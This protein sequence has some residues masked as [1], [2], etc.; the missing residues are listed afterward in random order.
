MAAVSIALSSDA[1]Y[2]CALSVVQ[3][4]HG[5]GHKAYFA[6]GCV[7]DMLL[8]LTPKDFDVATSATPDQ[9]LSLFAR[10]KAVGAHFGVILVSNE[11]GSLDGSNGAEESGSVDIEVAT[12]RNDGIYIDGRRPE[13]V[14]F[15]SDPREDVIR[16]DFT[17]NGMLLDAIRFEHTGDLE[18]CVLDFVGG[19]EDLEARKI[20]A[21]GDPITR[22]AEDKLRM[23]R[24]I[25]FAARLGFEID[26]STFAAIRMQAAQV[27]KVSP[28]RISNE[29]T[30]MLTEGHARRAFELLDESNL[31]TYVM[32]EA[33][34]MKGVAQPPEYHPEG[35]VW[36]H[37]MLLLERLP[38]ACSPTLAWGALL[39]DIGKPTT[40]T[41]P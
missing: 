10:T 26:S 33:V 2:R 28:E 30:R 38:A 4:L 14:R 17:I 21:I 24:A 6:G 1:H 3:S 41:C 20:R 16:R 31:L 22:F 15:S 11:L 32:W 37:T 29:L 12:F 13:A 18:A 9:V 5:A 27:N 35:D 8:G 25:R 36:T 34:R 40:F 7:R 19:R 23:L 39:H